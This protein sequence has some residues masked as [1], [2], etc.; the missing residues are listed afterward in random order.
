MS[1]FSVKL[2]CILADSTIVAAL[3]SI[4]LF[5][6]SRLVASEYIPKDL[7]QVQTFSSRWKRNDAF[8]LQCSE[9]TLNHIKTTS[10][11][12]GKYN[13]LLLAKPFFGCILSA[14]PLKIFQQQKQ[15]KNRA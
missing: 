4:Q 8:F 9:S 12:R 13:C 2:S 11:S 3:S 14:L 10:K 5:L 7:P 6:D 1:I 15:K